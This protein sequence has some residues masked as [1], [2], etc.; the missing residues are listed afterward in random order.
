MLP[1]AM[2]LEVY[3][4]TESGMMISMLPATRIVQ[5]GG[6]SLLQLTSVGKPSAMSKFGQRPM[7]IRIINDSGDNV[8]IG[9]VGEIIVRGEQVM[10]GYWN[11]AA[12]T[13]KTLVEG[14]LYTGD[15]G[16]F[17]E[18][19]YLY[20]IDRKKDII[21]VDGANVFCAEVEQTIELL[22][23]V[24]E[25]AL[26]GH[27]LSTDNEEIVA[28]IVPYPNVS[29]SLQDLRAFCAE[30]LAAFKLPTKLWLLD[31][32]PRTIVDKVDKTILRKLWLEAVKES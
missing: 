20:L 23:S 29:V 12:E 3:S 17:D 31:A 13:E 2:L 16:R 9:E 15:I 14:W 5:E 32:L 18:A 26:I 21:I 30:K 1:D 25:A 24:K 22:P 27:S 11:N 8:A 6:S 7:D 28:V 10:Q 19:G 4:Q